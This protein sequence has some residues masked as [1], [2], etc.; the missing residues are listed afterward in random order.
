[1]ASHWVVKIVRVIVCA[2]GFGLI[3]LVAGGVGM[4]VLAEAIFT[5]RFVDSFP[6]LLFPLEKLQ[7]LLDAAV[8][9]FGILGAA[10]GG[11]VGYRI[12]RSKDK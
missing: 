7:M 10:L 4:S 2:I 9:L 5:D 11:Y 6:N 12:T 8:G 3:G 1:M